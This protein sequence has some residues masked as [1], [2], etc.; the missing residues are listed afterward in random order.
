M[1]KLVQLTT[2]TTAHVLSLE[3]PIIPHVRPLTSSHKTLK[4]CVLKDPDNKVN[5][6]YCFFLNETGMNTTIRMASTAGC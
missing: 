6:F 2:Q 3:A 1:G 5:N 4:R